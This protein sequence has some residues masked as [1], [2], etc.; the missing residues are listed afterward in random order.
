V[1]VTRNAPNIADNV[2]VAA[3]DASNGAPLWS[4]PESFSRPVAL[5]FGFGSLLVDDTQRLVQYTRA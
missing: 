1:Y 2:V 3:Y 4:S 5:S